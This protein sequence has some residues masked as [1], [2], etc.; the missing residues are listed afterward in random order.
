MPYKNQGRKKDF[1][2]FD[3]D[4]HV[5]EPAAVWDEYIPRGQREFAKTHLYSD[6]DRGIRVLNGQ[7]MFLNPLTFTYPA[8]VWNPTIDKDLIGLISP[9]DPDWDEKLGRNAIQRDPHARLRE[10]DATGID[11]VM[12][13]PSAPM[14]MACLVKNPEAA[15]ISVRAYN[16]WANDYAAADRRRL[17]PCG[18]IP[19]QDVDLAIKELR[20]IA[21][22]G[23]KAAAVRPVICNDKYPTYPEFDPLWREFEVQG[24]ALGMHTF[25]APG[26]MSVPIAKRIQEVNGAQEIL[27]YEP[28]AYAYS[29]GQF[30]PNIMSAMGSTVSGLEPLS[31]IAEATSWLT[32]VLMSGWLDK[33]PNLRVA[34][35][36]SNAGWLPLVLEKAEG[37]LKLNRFYMENAGVKIGDPEE[38]FARQCFISFEADEDPVLRMWD[39]YEDVGIWASDMPHHDTMDAW[40]TIDRLEHHKVPR[41]VQEKFLGQNACRL[42]GIEQQLFVTE[43]PEEYVP[44]KISRYLD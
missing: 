26:A 35:L 12:V 42:Y 13:F 18:M 22:M 36:E 24:I 25:I 33:F 43:A 27:T 20:R 32:I 11:Q 9:A 19:M 6:N 38:A 28:E 3:C 29:P 7:T 30:V 37:F 1:P 17:F 5:F 31:F 39:I 44:Q 21:K 2:V 23:F 41:H 10:M 14:I 15:A 8:E 40:E 34:I 16:D 4:S